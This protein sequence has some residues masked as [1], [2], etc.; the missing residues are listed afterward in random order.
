MFTIFLKRILNLF[1]YQPMSIME[2]VHAQRLHHPFARWYWFSFYYRYLS[3]FTNCALG[4][5]ASFNCNHSIIN[6]ACPK[7][8]FTLIPTMKINVPENMDS[9][10]QLQKKLNPCLPITY[11]KKVT[12]WECMN[13]NST[14]IYSNTDT[15]LPW[16]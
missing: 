2:L 8:S 1:M 3:T 6:I 10:D 7:H 13:A 9:I 15:I 12:L 4:G 5:C 16:N 14:P 11:S